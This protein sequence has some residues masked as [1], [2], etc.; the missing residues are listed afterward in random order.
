MKRFFLLGDLFCSL[1]AVRAQAPALLVSTFQASTHP[2]L[3][4]GT[5]L[6][7]TMWV[8]QKPGLIA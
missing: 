3:I 4:R 6:P 5:I 2:M 8:F 7:V 1:A